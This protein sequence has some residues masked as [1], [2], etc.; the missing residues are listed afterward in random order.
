MNLFATSPDWLLLILVALLAA[1]TIQ[2]VVQ[3]RISNT[4]TVAILALA[5]IAIAVAGLQIGL[6]QNA[7]VFAVVLA[8]G[9]LLFSRGMLG[10]GDVKLLAAVA[11][12]SDLRGTPILI[13]A[14]LVC[15][16]LL[17][18]AILFLRAAVPDRFS[19]RVVTLRPGAGIPYGLA[20]S[21]GTLVAIALFR[22]G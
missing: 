21:A 2:D 18:L 20:I 3:L 8:A 22:Q 6:W 17:A 11:L 10:G 1:A 19:H 15:G 4:L 12:W 9:T 14:I 7:V 5:L 13:A 16:G